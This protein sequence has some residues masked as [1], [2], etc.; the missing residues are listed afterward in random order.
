MSSSAVSTTRPPLLTTRTSRTSPRT[1]STSPSQ[2]PPHEMGTVLERRKES[3][4]RPS[5]STSS[6][7]RSASAASSHHSTTPPLP[8]SSTTTLHSSASLSALPKASSTSVF[9]STTQQRSSSG[10]DL[11]KSVASSSVVSS[12]VS[13]VRRQLT[14]GSH[15]F[16]S[17]SSSSAAVPSAQ[18]HHRASSST[19]SASSGSFTVASLSSSSS[20]RRSPLPQPISTTAP[21]TSP[22]PASN[23]TAST[24]TAISPSPSSTT[25]QPPP[26][27]LDNDNLLALI[28][29]RKFQYM[30]T[31]IHS[32]PTPAAI[33]PN[34]YLGSIG[35]ARNHKFLCRNRI[36]H[37]L[38]IGN[39]LPVF[40]RG[41]FEYLHL[42]VQDGEKEDIRRHFERCVRFVERGRGGVGE[43][44]GRQSSNG[45][46]LKVTGGDEEKREAEVNGTTDGD[47]RE[48][49]PTATTT[50]NGDG[51]SSSGKRVD[52]EGTTAGTGVLLHCFAG[53]SRSVTILLAYLLTL[54]HRN[55]PTHPDI[56]CMMK[57]L[58]I[59]ASTT[60]PTT[61]TLVTTTTTATTTTATTTT[62]ASP[63]PLTSPSSS[64][65]A[66]PTPLTLSRLFDYV[67]LKRPEIKPNAGFV[68]QL[69]LL[70]RELSSVSY[71]LSQLHIGGVAA[72]VEVEAAVLGVGRVG[73]GEVGE[74]ERQRANEVESMA[75][76]ERGQEWRQF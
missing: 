61:S 64:P 68:A 14:N 66:H 51:S 50:A 9:A 15:S 26:N 34:L 49:S 65:P 53:R 11:K 4:D 59:P 18:Q 27:P 39:N 10:E 43:V 46:A 12:V 48:R 21:T 3:S 47:K 41:E 42:V 37:I 36:S 38:T 67:K 40:F 62:A 52:G 71:H 63:T 76:K 57:A 73:E 75:G 45:S 5:S 1:S 33:L 60:S 7:S 29:P 69:L 22:P 54:V 25:Q 19:S 56:Q 8:S 2:S 72:G 55:P 16:G 20:T 23:T 31:F 28:G 70:E 13:S 74:V 30:Q 6:T 17:H 44:M 35:A 58:D 24:S 32:D